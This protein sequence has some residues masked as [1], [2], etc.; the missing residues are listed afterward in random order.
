MLGHLQ[1]PVQKG[2]PI[3]QFETRYFAL[4]A[5]FGNTC[6]GKSLYRAVIS[7]HLWDV[8]TQHWQMLLPQPS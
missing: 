5:Q 4:H 7:Q 8:H 3:S 2:S 6:K 1:N